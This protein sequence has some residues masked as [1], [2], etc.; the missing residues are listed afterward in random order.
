MALLFLDYNN[1]TEIGQNILV[2]LIL[3]IFPYIYKALWFI[4]L[5]NIQTNEYI[6][7][8]DL[9]FILFFVAIE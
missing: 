6:S 3:V 4:H 9:Y 1:Q 5:N 7:L 2:E 8:S